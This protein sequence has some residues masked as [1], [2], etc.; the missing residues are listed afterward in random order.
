MWFVVFLLAGML[1]GAGCAAT[2]EP[3]NDDTEPVAETAGPSD[4]EVDPD[5]QRQTDWENQEGADWDAFSTAYSDGFDSGC[6]ELFGQS[7]NGS[8]YEDDV[9]YTVADCTNLNPSDPSNSSDLPTD[10]P[11]DPASDGE[12]LGE[13]EGCRALFDEGTVATLN[14]GTDTYTEDDCPMGS[15]VPASAPRPRP[16]PRPTRPT[17]SVTAAESAARQA[18]EAYT[19]SVGLYLTD[20]TA[21][22]HAAGEDWTCAV[23]GGQ[24]S[25]T[26]TIGGQTLRELGRK[27]GC[28]E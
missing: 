15:V 19:A 18:A 24:C 9:E 14:Y 6:E 23:D 10:V 21:R 28:A 16:K 22:C 4:E 17:T 1:A 12:S 8:L 25:G 7:P 13:D 27:V 11:D 2:E 20:W 3:A 5:E 26:V